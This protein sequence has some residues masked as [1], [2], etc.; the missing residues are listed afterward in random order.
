MINS[1]PEMSPEHKSFMK[2]KPAFGALC[3]LAVA[4]PCAADTFLLKDGI[5]LNGAVVS[6]AGDFYLVEFQVTKSIK[7]DRKIA[8][9]D[10]VKITA[11][12]GIK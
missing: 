1:R 5:T 4:L 7:D 10:V 12:K 11:A 9:A 6:E 2:Q 8:K 3:L